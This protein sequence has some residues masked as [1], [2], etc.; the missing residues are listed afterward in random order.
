MP[1]RSNGEGSIG[2][3]SGGYAARITL[4][5]GKR[6]AFYGKT[7]KEVDA[8]LDYAKT[9]LKQRT[10]L[11]D[12]KTIARTFLTQWIIDKQEEQDV[13]P[14]TL[15]RYSEYIHRHIIPV[16]GDIPMEELRPMHVHQIQKAVR[17]KGLS[18]TTINA[19]RKVLQNALND[20]IENEY[21]AT[22]VAAMTKGRKARKIGKNKQLLVKKLDITPDLGKQYLKAVK[23]DRYELLFQLLIFLGLRLSE[24]LGLRWSDIDLDKNN[25][26]ISIS[27]GL[28]RSQGKWWFMEPKSTESERTT[29]IQ[30]AIVEALSNYRLKQLAE[31]TKFDN[32]ANESTKSLWQGVADIHPFPDAKTVDVGSG[33]LVFTNLNGGPLINDTVSKRWIKAINIAE[34]PK[35]RLH[36]IRHVFPSLLAVLNE[37]PVT[38]QGLMAHSDMST[39]MNIYS[40]ASKTEQKKALGKLYE[41]L[42]N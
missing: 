1:K 12:G 16:I 27:R 26:R 9:L 28:H 40:Q 3:Y 25:G 39:T 8:K 18:K 38:V 23:G 35:I 13:R 11:P 33:E 36:D 37:N 22:N 32:V 14:T 41:M 20:A 19:T 5:N 10:E 4:P 21:V 15:Q 29:Y 17:N 2:T 24:T 34:L 7:R 42:T 6:K 31:K 30:P